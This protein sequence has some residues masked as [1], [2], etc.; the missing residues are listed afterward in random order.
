MEKTQ[1]RL[2]NLD[3]L[4]A[5]AI[6]AMV[7][8]HPVERLGSYI[9]GYEDDFWFIFGEDI[10]GS[11]LFVA[12]AFMLALGIGMIYSKNNNPSKMLKRGIRLYFLGYVFNFLRHGILILIADFIMGEI[13]DVTWIALFGL[14]I[15]HFAGL[16]FIIT[17][18]LKKLKLNDI[19]IFIISV[20]LSVIGSFIYSPKTGNPIFDFLLGH[21]V[22][23][24]E[25]S[26]FVFFNWYIT[27]G[28]GYLIGSVLYKTQDKENLYKK[29][30]LVSGIIMIIYLALTLRFGK[31]F[32]SIE[33]D[34]YAASTLEMIGLLSIDIFGLSALYF[35]LQKTDIS[36]FKLL[37][38][39]SKS[40]TVIYFVHWLF[41]GPTEIIICIMLEYI[42]T[43]PQ[44]YIY[45][46]VLLIVSLYISLR[47]TRRKQKAK[48]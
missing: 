39:M 35:L 42:F 38:D 44:I 7:I 34:Y 15:F 5:I 8:C 9:P 18:L 11:Y 32:L 13:V 43:Y 22:S 31:Y 2:Y 24:N 14:G 48:A 4:K 27:V 21:F 37:L 20:V 16:A 28:F 30:L 41:L 12:H 17:A 47:F 3:I 19:Q 25:M 33:H 23:T 36:K 6:I 45:A 46:I 26:S 40:I 29:M 10:L 1:T